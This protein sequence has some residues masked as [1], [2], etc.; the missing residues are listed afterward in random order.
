MLIKIAGFDLNKADTLSDSQ[1]EIAGEAI[2]NAYKETKKA[3]NKNF[4][5]LVTDISEKLMNPSMA[6]WLYKLSEKE[7]LMNYDIAK[8]FIA[9]YGKSKRKKALI[10]SE[11]GYFT[12]DQH[13]FLG[14]ALCV[15]ASRFIT[16]KPSDWANE[17]GKEPEIISI[18][19]IW[20]QGE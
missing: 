20:W 19:N 18:G 15:S 13:E 17:P 5:A 10:L 8:K 4:Y 6:K 16:K 1:L 7:M 12:A 9:R 14:W 2:F 11:R 3:F